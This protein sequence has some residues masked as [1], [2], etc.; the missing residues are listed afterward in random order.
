MK[1]A[2]QLMTV[3]VHRIP[4]QLPLEACKRILLDQRVRR[5]M[6]VDQ[7][8]RFEGLASDIPLLEGCRSGQGDQRVGE[9]A[10]PCRVRVSPDSSTASVLKKM[11][12]LSLIHI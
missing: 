11:L 3:A 12:N 9:I 4:G 10:D 1:T 5:L 6:L 7:S 8:G 2:S